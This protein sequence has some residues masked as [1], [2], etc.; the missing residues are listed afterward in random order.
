MPKSPLLEFLA[1]H[2]GV[3]GGPFLETTQNNAKTTSRKPVEM[4]CGYG[5]GHSGV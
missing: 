3:S 5:I 1:P 2:R 4:S